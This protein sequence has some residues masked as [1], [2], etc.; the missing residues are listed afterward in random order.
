MLDSREEQESVGISED[1]LDGLESAEVANEEGRGQEADTDLQVMFSKF[2]GGGQKGERKEKL[3]NVNFNAKMSN[4]VSTC[5]EYF[6]Q[7][8]FQALLDVQKDF[9]AVA[10]GVIDL[11]SGQLLLHHPRFMNSRVID[12]P[13]PGY[14]ISYS[15]GQMVRFLE[16]IMHLPG[17]DGPA[18]MEHLQVLLGYGLTGHTS[19]QVLAIFVGEGS[20][21]KSLLLSLLRKLLGPSYRDVRK[22]IVVNAKGQRAANKGAA[23]PLEAGLAGALLAV[24]EETD[25]S[26]TL[27]EA[28]MK[29][30][31]GSDIITARPLF[32]DF[33]TFTATVLLILCTNYLPKTDKTWSVALRRRLQLACFVKRYF[34]PHEK[35]Y[36]PGN[37]L[38]GTSLPNPPSH[39]GRHLQR[40]PQLQG[41]PTLRASSRGVGTGPAR[42]S[43][44]GCSAYS[45]PLARTLRAALHDH[46]R[47]RL[48]AVDRQPTPLR[49]PQREAPQHAPTDPVATPSQTACPPL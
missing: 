48:E 49:P 46:T 33:V 4:V 37:P 34:S 9:R 30:L 7:A 38:H 18:A 20:A 29:K 5:K 47:Q 11:R 23:S 13:F 12:W 35:G 45:A 2:I 39:S 31:T 14:G 28:G 26:D 8:D 17:E 27:D 24:V 22:E 25:K 36:D 3:V 1:I 40:A 6:F 10:N 19:N 21:G 42:Y 16:D 41:S 43:Q 44:R 15:R 32:K